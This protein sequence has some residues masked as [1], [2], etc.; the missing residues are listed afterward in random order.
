VIVSLTQLWQY[1]F[2]QHFR[3]E[4]MLKTTAP[5][6]G[7]CGFM[8]LVSLLSGAVAAGE[9]FS[10][11]GRIAYGGVMRLENRD[12]NLL[13]ANNAAVIG[14]VGHGMG[15]NAD[16]ANLN[17]ERHD[18]V[19][20]AWLGNLDLQYQGHG[21][22]GLA[23]LK[24]WY[25]EGLRH[26]AR[27][28]GNSISRFGAG[29]PL[30]DAGAEKLSRFSGV[31]LGEAWLERGLQLSQGQ[32]LLRAGRQLTPW[33]ER[34]PAL[35]AMGPRDYPAARRAG[36]I[37]QETRVAAPMLFARAGFAPG[38]ALEAFV[39]SFRPSALDLCGSFWAIGDYQA[40][41]CNVV[42]AG[43]PLGLNDRA[44]VAQGAVMQR[45]PT[46][47]PGA[48]NRGLALFWQA[49][50]NTDLGLYHARFGWRTP[51]PS[52]RRSTRVG[53][54]LVAG[55]PD[56]LNM[57]FFT[58]YVPNVPLTALT[59]SRRAGA[60]TYGAELSWRERVPFMLSPAEA[61]PPFLN[62]TMP[63]LLR[64]SVDAVPPGGIFRGYD[65]YSMAQLQLSA[66]RRWDAFGLPFTGL[67]EVVGKRTPGLPDQTVRRYG[68][69]DVYGPGP[70]NGV[71]TVMT[72][73]AARQCSLRGYQTASAWSY[74]LRLDARL[75]EVLPRLATKL[76]AGFGH[77]VKG[78]SGDF[79]INEGR[80]TLSLGCQFEYAKRYF[81]DLAYVGIW[82]GDYNP[83][84]DRDTLALS[85]G[86]RF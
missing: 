79:A 27:P 17:Y 21:L 41:G 83:L 53:P 11:S 61:L 49:D 31:A 10:V 57:R 81:A 5:P 82:G 33:S 6:A 71:C 20:R 35:E 59:L 77:E 85:A 16:D 30:G 56:G 22:A 4:A 58:E 9:G 42:M 65:L 84:K 80:H 19:S 50:P 76:V 43:P 55:D 70:V 62:A 1:E 29:Q 48:P 52:V 60:T 37:A 26:D 39:Q 28:W 36:S 7:R 40:E 54:P 66:Q 74:R 34:G 75:P 64:A 18:W 68:R 46:V 78:W 25:D 14:L 23:R 45:L 2:H 38:W 47:K 8:V 15:A 24:A 72:G 12:P 63:S 67:V 69:A 13:T 44:R 3:E 86:V 73:D 51:M 32:L